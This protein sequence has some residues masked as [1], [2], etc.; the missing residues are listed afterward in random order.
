MK[1][2]SKGAFQ[3]LCQQFLYANVLVG[4]SMILE[5]KRAKKN[6]AEDNVDETSRASIEGL[7]ETPE[8]SRLMIGS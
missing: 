3:V 8:A 2:L 4:L 7:E 5:D 6:E 1:R